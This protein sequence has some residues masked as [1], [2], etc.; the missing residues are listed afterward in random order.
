[1]IGST[2]LGGRCADRETIRQAAA[3]SSTQL[4]PTGR[5]FC[6]CGGETPP[7][8]FFVPTHDR[9]A[10]AAVLRERYGSIA[11]SWST[12]GLALIARCPKRA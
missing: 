6:G 7:G 5:C 9:V 3:M 4:I 2:S 1:L 10:E 12:T 8:R 11:A